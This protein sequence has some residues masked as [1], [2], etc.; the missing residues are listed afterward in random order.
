[1]NPYLA[2]S[3]AIAVGVAGQIILKQG[4]MIHAQT[5]IT[6]LFTNKL[7]MGGL[8]SYALSAVL[9]IYSL[10]NIPVSAAF[11]SVSISYFFVALIAHYLWGE[12][13]GL[14]QIV[15]LILI[16]IGVFLMFR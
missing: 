4:A 9:Y 8:F 7:V 3:I 12:P 2:L 1:M 15:A 13:F 11:S 14:Q 10:R 5:S 16:S 6:F